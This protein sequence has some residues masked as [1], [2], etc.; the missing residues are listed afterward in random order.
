MFRQDLAA[1]HIEASRYAAQRDCSLEH[2]PR[3]AVLLMRFV[4]P[5]SA[6]LTALRRI[7]LSLEIDPDYA[8]P[9]VGRPSEAWPKSWLERVSGMFRRLGRAP[10]RSDRLAQGYGVDTSLW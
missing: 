7:C 1:Q 9:R 2:F 4:A 3:E 5:P 8:F 10:V 6:P